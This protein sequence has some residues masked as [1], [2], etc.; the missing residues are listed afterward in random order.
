MSIQHQQSCCTQAEFEWLSVSLVDF[1]LV[2]QSHEKCPETDG[3][4]ALN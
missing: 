2:L 1:P 3:F 4:R